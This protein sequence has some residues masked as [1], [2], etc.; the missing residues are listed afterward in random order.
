M[1][2]PTGGEPIQIGDFLNP[3]S[4]LTPGFAGAVAMM[5]S[6]TLVHAFGLPPAWSALVL[7]F[8]LGTIV[9][10]ASVSLLR[11]AV[12]Y[13][14]NSLIIF[15]VAFGTNTLGLGASATNLS[16]NISSAA[17][18]AE[19][20]TADIQRVFDEAVKKA[21]QTGNQND[22]AV[23][24]Q[25]NNLINILRS[26]ALSSKTAIV[27]PR[28]GPA[29][30]AVPSGAVGNTQPKPATTSGFFQPWRF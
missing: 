3:A 4:M 18:A 29:G 6:N 20:P 25:K 7:S 1:T 26:G 23:I 15:S 16:L 24:E 27:T 12:Y 28:Q 8:L 11:G 19:A 17:Y 5:I 14:L 21:A 13:V 22:P 30:T 10:V 9:W 2:E